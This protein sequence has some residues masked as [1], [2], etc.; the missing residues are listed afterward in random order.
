MAGGLF[1]LLDDI[2]VL[3]KAAASS[4]DDV[5]TGAAK[6]AVKTSGVIVDDVAAAPQYVTGLSPKRE[7]P[8]VWKITKGSLANK[9][10]IV[11]PLLLILSWIAPVLF[12]YL[13]IIGGTYLSYEGAEKALEWMHIVKE[14]HHSAE[15][16]ADTPEAL[17]KSMV[18][19]AVMT[20]LVLSM[21]IMTI[22]LS[23]IHAH[24]FWTRLATL[25]V[26][27]ILMTVLVYG[28]VAALIRLDD[29][30]RFMARRRS[31]WVRILGLGMIRAMPKVFDLLSIVG[32]L[33]MLWVG[34]HLIWENLGE[35]GL[36]FFHDTLHGL[37]HV[38]EPAGGLVSWLGTAVVSMVGGLVWGTV[39]FLLVRGA[40]KIVKTSRG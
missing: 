34:G 39:V 6:T 30:G 17:E 3:A 32:T 33:A 37:E 7:L 4:I 26:V 5:A 9:F 18:R 11:I 2:S 28:A 31:R 14:E 10:L 23:T 20:D 1:A 22:S 38:L 36:H 29:T 12:P 35:V 16:V 24:G 21:E 40:M 13:L 25:C 27:A 8:V 19:S 15:V